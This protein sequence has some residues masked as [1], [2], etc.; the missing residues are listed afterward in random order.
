MTRHAEEVLRAQRESFREKFGRDWKSGDPVFFDPDMDVPT[1]MSPVKIEADVLKAM[2]KA[3]APPEVMYAYRKTGL[4]MVEGLSVD[5]PEDR[6]KQWS[7]AIEEYFAIEYA[8][9]QNEEPHPEG[10]K[11]E[12]PELLVS[13]FSQQDF[14]HVRACLQAMAPIEGSRPMKLVAR[15]EL[16]AACLATACEH[17]FDSAHGTGSPERASELYD[18]AEELVVRRARELYAQGPA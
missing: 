2:R 12:I 4:I 15:I 9:A 3:G 8:K 11:T 7:D 10:W 14:D 5:W 13:D 6:R 18:K 16:A 1:P 17:A